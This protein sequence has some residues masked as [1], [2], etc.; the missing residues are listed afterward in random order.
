MTL[1]NLRPPRMPDC[2]Y[3]HHVSPQLQKWR[4]NTNQAETNSLVLFAIHRH[5]KQGAMGAVDIL[6]LPSRCRIQTAS[7]S[8][9]LIKRNTASSTHYKIKTLLWWHISAIELPLTTYKMSTSFSLYVDIIKK[10]STYFTFYVD[11]IKKD[12]DIKWKR[13]RLISL[14]A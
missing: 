10:M 9:V 5:W 6:V 3:V 14:F 1:F 13:C 8:F 4:N 2:I 12:V 11:I 7:G